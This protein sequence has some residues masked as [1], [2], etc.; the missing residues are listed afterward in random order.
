MSDGRTGQLVRDLAEGV[1]ADLSEIAAELEAVRAKIEQLGE[2]ARAINGLSGDCAGWSTHMAAILEEIRK[3][4][5]EIPAKLLGTPMREPIVSTV[6]T[7]H[8]ERVKSARKI[9]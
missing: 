3:S 1:K 2:V 6:D 7:E 9:A 5:R 8:A 4:E